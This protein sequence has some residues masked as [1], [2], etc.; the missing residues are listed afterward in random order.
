MSNYLFTNGRKGW[1][2]QRDGVTIAIAD[3]PEA[4]EL[5]VRALKFYEHQKESAPNPEIRSHLN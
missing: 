3:T 5:I 2:I 1:L 4:A